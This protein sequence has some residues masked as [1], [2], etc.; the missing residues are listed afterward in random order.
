MVGDVWELC[1]LLGEASSILLE[2]FSRFL[3]ALAEVPRIARVDVGPLEVPLKH[4]D[5]IGPVMDLVGQEF[6]E[7]PTSSVVEEKW[8]LPDDGS[9]VPSSASQLACQLEI[10]QS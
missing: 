8:K 9:I 2:G 10:R 7:P 5:Q 6:L 3:L 1:L 4:L